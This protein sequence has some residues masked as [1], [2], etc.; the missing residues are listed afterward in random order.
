MKDDRALDVVAQLALPRPVGGRTSSARTLG[1]KRGRAGPAER[2]PRKV[3]KLPDG[4][5]GLRCA[6][7]ERRCTVMTASRKYRS[8]PEAP[9][10]SSR[11]RSRLVAAMTRTSTFRAPRLAH[12]PDG[13]R[14]DGPAGAS[15]G[16]ERQMLPDRRG[17]RCRRRRPLEGADAA[18]AIP[19][20]VKAPPLRGQR[21]RSRPGSARSAPQS[22]MTNALSAQRT[23]LENL[24]SATT[25]L[26][27]A[28][29]A[30][31][32]DVDVARRDLPEGR[33]SLRMATLVPASAPNRSTT[34]RRTE[35]DDR[36]G[37]SPR[38]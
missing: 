7:G 38:A 22:T 26:P 1:E 2:D 12:P 9:R 34:R 23:P 29:L 15:A 17:T 25:S 31:D 30:L 5:G 37:S 21:A 3:R 16:L 36:P 27:V 28:A 14:L 6:R 4:A 19:A 33:K 32:K 20:P 35:T 24:Q 8:S 18:H 11:W 10:G 13:A